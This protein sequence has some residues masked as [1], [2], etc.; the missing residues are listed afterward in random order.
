MP[1]NTKAY[2]FRCLNCTQTYQVKS[3]KE[4]NL[5]RLVDGAYSAMVTALKQNAAPNLFLLNYGSEWTVKNLVLF[6]SAVFTKSV[7]EKRSP[8]SE[9][10][11]R[12][13]WVGCNILL[14][15]IPSEARIA[16]V[17]DTAIIS[18]DSV[19]EE[20]RKYNSLKQ[21]KWELRGWTLDIL[22]AVQQIGAPEFRLERVYQHEAEFRGLHPGNRNIK[23]K[24][25][26]QL[27]I[28]RDLGLI[29]FLGGGTYRLKSSA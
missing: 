10:A 21:V 13:G 1:A 28:L 9:T 3:Q 29:E 16:V 14:S 22:K 25:R 26:Q 6:P 8:L 23:A 18:P 17:R 27:Q 2:D 5:R 15:R 19:R 11:R 7:L 12:A 24:I 4:L 20:Y